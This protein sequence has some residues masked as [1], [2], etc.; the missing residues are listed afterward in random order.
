MALGAERGRI[1][2]MILRETLLLI[3]CGQLIGLPLAV[4]ASHLIASQL[5]GLRPADPI[6]FLAACAGMAA[7]ALAASYWPARRAASVDP[8]RALR[9]E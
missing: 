5:F 3:V 4:L 2:R 8:M 7:V 9:T 1:V 6:T